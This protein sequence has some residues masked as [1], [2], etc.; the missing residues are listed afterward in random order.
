MGF[1]GAGLINSTAKLTLI[2][3]PPG[4]SRTIPIAN[5]RH[6]LPTL[7]S[8]G[9]PAPRCALFVFVLG[10]LGNAASES[11]KGG[12]WYLPQR[13]GETKCRGNAEARHCAG[14]WFPGYSRSCSFDN[15]D[16]ELIRGALE[17]IGRIYGR[18]GIEF[19][20]GGA[21]RLGEWAQRR[22]AGA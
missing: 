19:A 10:N 22:G 17:R 21:P 6:G 11:V 2:L 15:P 8:A 16:G 5:D 4:N 14:P 18:R 9:R 1:I 3:T 12:R 13:G 7:N 20:T